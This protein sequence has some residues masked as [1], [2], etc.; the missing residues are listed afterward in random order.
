MTHLNLLLSPKRVYG[1]TVTAS[2]VDYREEALAYA[3]LPGPT[4]ARTPNSPPRIHS[5]Q[6]EPSLVVGDAAG[7]VA[8]AHPGSVPLMFPFAAERSRD[9]PASEVPAV[10]ALLRETFP[11]R[12]STV[13]ILTPPCPS[14]ALW[15]H[16]LP[17]MLACRYPQVYRE[18]CLDPFLERPSK[19]PH[20]IQWAI[21][22]DCAGVS[23]G[24]RV[25]GTNPGLLSTPGRRHRSSCGVST[26]STHPG[27]S[28]PT[29]PSPGDRT[30]GHVPSGSVQPSAR[31]LSSRSLLWFQPRST[32][33]SRTCC[34]PSWIDTGCPTRNSAF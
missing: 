2:G 6:P 31:R 12:A 1:V 23:A 4:R 21:V 14:V 16:S 3:Q 33:S 17:E 28:A 32:T 5:G 29:S 18:S 15:V 10:T 25:R 26:R 24:V 34:P 9:L 11:T 19:H 20:S 7:A 22:L 27:A 8:A 30:A 13:R